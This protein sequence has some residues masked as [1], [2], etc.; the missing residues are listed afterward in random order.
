VTDLAPALRASMRPA[1][2]GLLILLGALFLGERLEPFD[3][4]GMALI[5]IGL[6]TIDRRLLTAATSARRGSG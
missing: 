1:E 3:F 2:W 5:T 4:A 6:V